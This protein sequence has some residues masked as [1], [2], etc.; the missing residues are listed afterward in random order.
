[1]KKTPFTHRWGQLLPR[2]GALLG[3]CATLLQAVATTP[4]PTTPPPGSPGLPTLPQVTVE[5]IT[6]L[7]GDAGT[8]SAVF[9]VTLSSPA[10]VKASLHF[11]AVSD[12]EDNAVAGVDYLPVNGTLN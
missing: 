11:Q 6:V 10:T 4:P 8:R 9:T 5:P 12:P 1:M 7:E 2:W 3:T